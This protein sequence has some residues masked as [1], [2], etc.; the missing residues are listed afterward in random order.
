MRA[1][2]NEEVRELE[3]SVPGPDIAMP[4]DW[5]PNAAL[6]RLITTGHIKTWAVELNEDKG[7]AYYETM[8]KGMLALRVHRAY[9]ASAGSAA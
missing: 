1:L 5:Y 8:P 2:T 4:D 7:K 6:C 9:L 3:E